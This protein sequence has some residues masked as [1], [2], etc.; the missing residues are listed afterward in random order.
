MQRI[1]E[2]ALVKFDSLFSPDR[3]IWTLESLRQFHSLFVDRFDD[4]Q[5]NFL[6]KFKKQ[7]EGANNDIVQLAAELLY[8][9]QFFT[10]LTGPDKKLENVTTILS[11]G[12]HS[13]QIPRWAVEGVQHKIAADQSFNQHRPFHLAW[14]SEF[15]IH[16]QELQAVTRD[17][18]LSDPFGFAKD[19]RSIEFERGA[20]QPMQEAWL[21][22]A[23]PETFESIS[24]RNDK[25]QIR[26]AFYDRLTKGPSENIDADLLEIRNKLTEQAGAGFHFYRSPIVEQWKEANLYEHDI[27][28]IR[29]SRSREKYADFSAEEKAAHKRVHEALLRLGQVA[30]DELGGPRN[31]VLKR[32]SG[33]HPESGI[34]G[35]K[36]KDL[37]FGIYRKE[38]E[39]KFLGNPQIFMIVSGRGIEWG[40]SPLTHPD[41]FSNQEMRRRTREIAKAVLEQLPVAGSL[42]AQELASQLSESGNW[43]FRRKQRL[44]PKQS[45]FASLADWLSF[46]HTDEGAKNAGGG[47]TRY[48]LG[49][50]IDGLELVE[51]VKQMTQLFKPLMERII[52][53]SPPTAAAFKEP[54]PIESVSPVALTPFGELLRAFLQELSLVRGGPFQKTDPLWNAMSAVKNRLEQFEP[55]QS[56]PNFQVNI[57]VGQ[58]NWATVPWIAILNTNVTKSTQEGVYIVFLISKELNRIF[59]TLNQG[60]TNL[61]QELGQREAQKQMLDVAS[62]TR[63]VVSELASAGFILDNEIE[64]G[65]GGWLAKNYEIGTIAHIDFGTDN[66]P[67]DEHMN[68]LLEALIKAYDRAVDET[69]SETLPTKDSSLETQAI[70]AEAYRIEDA[71]SELF[72]EQAQLEHLLTIWDAKKNII[73]QGAP[74][75]GKSFVAKRLAYLILGQKDS[76]R[77]ET[78]Q[79]HQSYSY[80]DFVQGYRPNG[81][82]GFTLRD[83]VFHRFC[84]KARLSPGRKHVFIIDEINR[85][86][87]SKILGE[88]ML[89]VEPDKR[90]P[91]WATSLT[92]AQ[93]DEPRFFVPKNVYLLG[94]MNTADR[95]LSMVDYALRRRFSFIS[96]EPMF[97]SSK[98]RSLLADNGIPQ[99]MID[100]IVSRMIE[101]NVAIGEDR[102][103]LGPGYR[104]GHSFFVP[105]ED[106]EYDSG[107][108]RRVIE[109][110]VHPL[111]EEYWFDD[112]DKAQGWLQKLLEGSAI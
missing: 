28:L 61:V 41:D 68:A 81:K 34:R 29:Q 23:F 56:R 37:W 96:L 52:A 22:I 7:L 82:G 55:V 9:Q 91:A 79:F 45:E 21:H 92:Y 109:T 25:K 48:A 58:G 15:L 4:G 71:L 20:F 104:I 88:L 106:F 110:E 101:L 63:S 97:G 86:N 18:L 73:L 112:P 11:W 47:I 31:Y 103:N 74:G 75:V 66:Y 60:T 19:V 35:G 111:L 54:E 12:A 32:T 62:K 94:M 83:G 70:E 8:V 17:K 65:G 14:L 38:N 99:P 80:E 27:D 95:S 39:D 57:S 3:N 87:L 100:L 78:V 50:E 72:L 33:F 24:S 1:R 51:E 30:L 108:Y 67:N 43:H 102:A 85:G 13:P 16:W 2:T 5:G 84:E 10:S 90:G 49:K 77:I 44:D 53:E 36:P 40:F 107:W 42:E 69:P 105:I 93:P 46:L 64:L 6:E 89:L 59:L 26:D 76:S 98:F